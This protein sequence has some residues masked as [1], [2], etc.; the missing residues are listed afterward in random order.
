M[1]PA[2]RLFLLTFDPLLSLRARANE[3]AQS[4]FVVQVTIGSIPLK[5]ADFFAGC[6]TRRQARRDG[7]RKLLHS[8]PLA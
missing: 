3:N 6:A 5:I 7:Q 4:D 2:L 1:H 8:A